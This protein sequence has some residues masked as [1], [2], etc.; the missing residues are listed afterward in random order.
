[1]ASLNILKL[2]QF[3]IQLDWLLNQLE[4]QLLIIAESLIVNID[5]PAD[6]TTSVVDFN[7]QFACIKISSNGGAK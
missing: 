4:V 5:I 3:H 6:V 2:I 7:H 1:M